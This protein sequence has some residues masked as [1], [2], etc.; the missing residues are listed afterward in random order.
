M[1]SNNEDLEKYEVI[2]LVTEK[3][4]PVLRISVHYIQLNL[5][6]Q[7]IYAIASSKIKHELESIGVLF[8]DEDTLMDGLTFSRVKEL[9]KKSGLDVRRTVWYYQQFLKYAFSYKS[10]YTYYLTWDADTIPLNRIYYFKSGK[11]SFIEKKEFHK[12]YFDTLNNLFNGKIYRYS[13][14]ISFIAENMMFNSKIVKEIIDTIEKNNSLKGKNFF[15]RIINAVNPEYF[16]SG[17][18]EFETYGNYVKIKYP[19]LYGS[20]NLRT[21]RNGSFFVGLEPLQSQVEWA[22]R[23]FDIMSIEGRELFIA[24][25]SKNK[26]FQKCF[27][28]RTISKLVLKGRSIRRSLLGLEKLDYD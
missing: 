1:E 14:D 9:I 20:L 22:K 10:N 27:R 23:D 2:L 3:N 15:E 21:L 7:R 16:S 11:P 13:Q 6:A 26:W 28:L 24:K 8:I 18:S 25:W 4:L 17:F 19:E 5:G 12:G